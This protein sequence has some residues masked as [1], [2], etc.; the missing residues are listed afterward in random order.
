M[1][2]PAAPLPAGLPG[3]VVTL[4]EVRAAGIAPARLLRRDMVRI[5]ARLYAPAG[6]PVT[7]RD[8]AAAL[9]REDPELVVVGISAA[10]LWGVP[11]PRRLEAWVPGSPVHVTSLGLRRATRSTAGIV[12]HSRTLDQG[13]VIASGGVRALSAARTFVELGALL[14]VDPLVATGDALVRRPR[15]RLEGRA[16]PWTTI[17]ALRAASDRFSGRGAR[18]ARA[19]LP[20]VRMSADS[21]AEAA[22]RLGVGRAGLPIPL[23]NARIV[24]GG[25]ELGEPD[26]SWP[27]LRVCAEH[28]GP[29]HLTPEQ[30]ARD[31][32]R[33]ELRHRHGWIEVRTVSTDLRHGCA[34]GV[35]RLREALLRHGWRP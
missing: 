9:C 21:P 11:L 26:L 13:D 7:E 27:A 23:A 3:P 34:R 32:A 25:V 20:L 29:R 22:L 2:R 24:E 30:P 19:A 8:V 18:T 31:I 15:P 10:H 6:A 28:E 17:A 35:A 12:R 4:A 14:D 16:E 1:S 5:G 33:A